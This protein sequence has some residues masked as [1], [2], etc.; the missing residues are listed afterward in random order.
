MRAA[1]QTRQHART[2]SGPPASAL[3]AFFLPTLMLSTAPASC[4]G[5]AMAV[6][7]CVEHVTRS[8]PAAMAL[9]GP[10]PPPPQSA[11]K[12]KSKAYVSSVAVQSDAVKYRQ[13]Y[14]EL[15]LKVRETESVRRG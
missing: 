11:P 12:S 3:G 6:V 2:S 13:K 8:Q 5:F 4:S 10:N 7:K 14:K 9:P 1:A 15:K